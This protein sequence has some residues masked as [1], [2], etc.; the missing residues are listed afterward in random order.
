MPSETAMT[1][2]TAAV[3]IEVPVEQDEQCGFTEIIT[4]YI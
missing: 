4:D 2:L 1:M 3:A